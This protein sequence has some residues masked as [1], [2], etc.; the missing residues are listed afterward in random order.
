[1]KWVIGPG[2][3]EDFW[4]RSKIA[5]WRLYQFIIS[6]LWENPGVSVALLTTCSL[7]LINNILISHC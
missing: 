3:E 5:F 4:Y 7:L 2:F 1:M 6:L